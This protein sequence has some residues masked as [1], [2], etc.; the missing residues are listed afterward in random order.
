MTTY[1]YD[2]AAAP[3]GNGLSAATAF[4]NIDD[5]PSGAHTHLFKRGARHTFSTIPAMPVVGDST[6]KVGKTLSA[7]VVFASYG[8]EGAPPPILTGAV[9]WTGATSSE[10]VNGITCTRIEHEGW[11]PSWF[12]A[13]GSEAAYLNRCAPTADDSIDSFM[14]NPAALDDIMPDAAGVRFVPAANY[15]N[16]PPPSHILLDPTKEVS[17]TKVG[18]GNTKYHIKI[19]KPGFWARANAVASLIGYNVV[20]R[21]GSN[22]TNYLGEILSYDAVEGS[23]VVGVPE[24]VSNG[25]QGLFFYALLGHPYGLR[26]P[27]QYYVLP[28]RAGCVANLPPGDIEIAC[29]ATCFYQTNDGTSFFEGETYGVEN[30]ASF[31]NKTR[32]GCGILF[33]QGVDG[34]V[35]GHVIARNLRSYS[36]EGAPARAGTAGVLQNITL[37]PVEMYECL[38]VKAVEYVPASN[39]ANF[40]AL[41]PIYSEGTGG[42]V[43]LAGFGDGPAAIKDFVIGPRASIHDNH[44]NIYQRIKNATLENGVCCGA[45][46]P[47][48]TQWYDAGGAY[49]PGSGVNR[50]FRNLWLS[51]LTGID[52]ARSANGILRSD[53]GLYDSTIDRVFS[54]YGGSSSFGSGA[55][56]EPNTN[57]VVSR[58]VFDTVARSSTGDGNTWA[59]VTFRN[60]VFFGKSGQASAYATT[61]EY[62]EAF[63][64]TCIDCVDVP[65][66]LFNG[67]ITD[68]I[69]RCFT[70]NDADDGYEAVPA[71]ADQLGLTMPAYGAAR[72]I[73]KP[74]FV[75]QRFYTGHQAGL[76]Y[77][78]V[79]NVNP[80]STVE[81][82]E[83]AGDN[84]KLEPSLA[85]GI[86]VIPSVPCPDQD[87]FTMVLRVTDEGAT[88]GPHQD[89]TYEI[90]IKRWLSNGTV[91]GPFT[92][93]VTDSS[94][95]TPQVASLDPFYI[96]VAA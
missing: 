77:G 53:D 52:G 21:I 79:I 25:D 28:E 39:G 96:T 12:P 69:W 22:F 50:V 5:M 7:N 26:A 75:H 90:P 47:M 86:N 23:V 17:F 73:T 70:R 44:A 66:S 55:G 18:S 92:L 68:D 27:R 10:V 67:V 94:S 4:D 40:E 80:L 29:Y 64:G 11:D 38:G 74:A 63:G 91:Y 45:Q 35:T 31:L 8:D 93:S 61:S 51:G 76:M 16:G 34:A 49:P 58:S 81:I 37:G 65:G 71:F 36:R 46:N 87:T 72:T 42:G 33:D 9:R 14:V 15:G 13:V 83:G 48:A 19:I 41:G 2:P 62:I 78:T 1:Y 32:S 43:R 3:G 30:L 84:D 54:V 82:L 95:P 56:S 85:G 89:F 88:N 60:C 57:L 24:P 6:A 20:T 59:G